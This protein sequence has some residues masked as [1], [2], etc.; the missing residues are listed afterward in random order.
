[1]N[2]DLKQMIE[3]VGRE[4]QVNRDLSEDGVTLPQNFALI[5]LRKNK[6]EYVD[7]I[8]R[9]RMVLKNRVGGCKPKDFII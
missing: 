3:E 8:K 5:G 6:K 1:M 2:A 9:E 7:S 4:K